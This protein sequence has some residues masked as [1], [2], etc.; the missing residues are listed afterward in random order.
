MMDESKIFCLNFTEINIINFGSF[1]CFRNESKS[2]TL[3]SPWRSVWRSKGVDE[4]PLEPVHHME[5]YR[6]VLKYFHQLNMNCLKALKTYPIENRGTTKLIVCEDYIG[7]AKDDS[8]WVF[9]DE[10][11]ERSCREMNDNNHRFQISK[12]THISVIGKTIQLIDSTTGKVLQEVE[13]ES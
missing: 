8:T 6:K 9:F 10:N 4:E 13:L 5:A 1:A 12:I 2:V 7:Y 11:M 3:S